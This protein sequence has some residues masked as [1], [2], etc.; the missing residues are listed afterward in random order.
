MTGPSS[1]GL[2]G[3]LPAGERILWQGSPA[4]SALARTAFHTRLAAG[5]F[6]A[7]AG[8]ALVSGSQVGL[9][10]VAALGI[11]AV[12]LLHLFAWGS[13]RTTVYTLTDR[14]IVMRVGIAVPKFVNVPLRMIASVDLAERSDG[15]GDGA[16]TPVGTP[17]LGY[18][19][20]W[21][22]AQAWRLARP[23][24]MLRSLAGA[25]DVAALIARACAG[26]ASERQAPEA[27]PAAEPAL[28]EAQA[29]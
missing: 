22:H 9:G 10:M 16:V 6:V 4:R 8:V 7:L 18:F 13:A 21:P 15:T 5:Y 2:P 14:R 28:T 26:A 11:V 19:A 27:E 24:P 12:A 29:A 1:R 23:R 25:K 20:L 3:P 17:T